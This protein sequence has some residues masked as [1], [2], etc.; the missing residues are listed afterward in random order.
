MTR[1]VPL[2]IKL[3]VS[4]MRWHFAEIDDMLFDI[5]YRLNAGLFVFVP[6][7]EPYHNL[8]RRGICHALLQT[9]DYRVLRIEEIVVNILKRSGA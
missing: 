5:A 3:P 1:S 2:M 9:L 4:V 7:Q 8:D 6:E